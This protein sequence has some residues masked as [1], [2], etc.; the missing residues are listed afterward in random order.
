MST[1]TLSQEEI[2]QIARAFVQLDKIVN[3]KEEGGEVDDA[4]ESLRKVLRKHNILDDWGH[5]W[6]DYMD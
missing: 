3:K 2:Q 4:H 5:V 6:A 1:I